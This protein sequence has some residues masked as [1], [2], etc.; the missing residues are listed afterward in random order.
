MAM[1]LLLLNKLAA[2]LSTS[3]EDKA[4]PTISFPSTEVVS[5]PEQSL[6]EAMTSLR[7]T[8]SHLSGLKHSD[9]QWVL[10]RWVDQDSTSTETSHV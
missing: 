4:L 10:D 5:Q 7:L 8:F 1:V 3:S 6:E 2:L 9:T